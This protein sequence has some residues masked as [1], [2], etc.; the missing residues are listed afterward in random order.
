MVIIQSGPMVAGVVAECIFIAAEPKP[1]MVE[2]RLTTDPGSPRR[3]PTTAGGI[4]KRLD[5]AL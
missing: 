5:P 2:F 3:E 4:F 1:L